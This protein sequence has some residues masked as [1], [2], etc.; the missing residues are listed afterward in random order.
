[1]KPRGRQG[2]VALWKRRGGPHPMVMGV[3]CILGLPVLLISLPVILPALAWQKEWDRRRLHGGGGVFGCLRCGELLGKAALELAN[4]AFAE[5]LAKLH[6]ESPGLYLRLPPRRLR[7][8]CP[9]CG[10]QCDFDY[11]SVFFMP[12][13]NPC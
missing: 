3:A 13:P 6:A 8:L 11:K 9:H 10:Q 2:R 12:A 1:M 7:A 4:E 5:D